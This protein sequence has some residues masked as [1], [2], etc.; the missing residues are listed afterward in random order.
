LS[1]A[2]YRPGSCKTGFSPG[3]PAKNIG[4]SASSVAAHFAQRS[5]TTL[6]R[7][8]GSA[9]RARRSSSHEPSGGSYID[10]S[11]AAGPP[12]SQSGLLT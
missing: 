8:A 9:A 2:E 6:A 11:S 7:S 5:R 3:L 1:R 10:H 12:I 4:A